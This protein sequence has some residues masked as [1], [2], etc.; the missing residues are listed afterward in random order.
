MTTTWI[1]IADA[2]RARLLAW[3]P[4]DRSLR[5]VSNIDHPAGRAPGRDL[6]SDRPGRR[7]GDGS[8]RGATD[9][10]DPRAKQEDRFAASL[11]EHLES[12]AA[13][14]GFDDLAVVAPPA[15]LGR[16][17][18]AWSKSVAGR[19]REELGVDLA[20]LPDAALKE[21][22]SAS[23]DWLDPAPAPRTTP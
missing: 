5:T 4:E 10:A 2:G 20:G 12:A 18:A 3:T 7:A 6:V 23:F 15:F 17:R 21:R 1:L 19:V 14:G 13:D 16:L 11:A 22:L 8:S 9:G